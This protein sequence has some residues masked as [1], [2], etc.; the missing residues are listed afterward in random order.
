MGIIFGQRA[1]FVEVV[2]R[3][4]V[5]AA[6]RVALALMVAP[7]VAC[8]GDA[9]SLEPARVTA[10]VIGGTLSPVEDDA[11]VMLHVEGQNGVWN[12]CTATLISPRIV[13]TAKHCVSAVQ[14]GNFV[15]RGNGELVQDGTGAGVF[16]QAVDPASIAIYVGATPSGAPASRGVQVVATGSPDACHDDVAM[17]VLDQPVTVAGFIPLRW[18]VATRVGEGVTLVGYGIGDPSDGIVRRELAD[19]RIADVSA[20]DASSADSSATTPPRTFV[21]PGATVCYGDSGGPALSAETGALVGTYSRISGDCF[22]AESRNT[23]M[24]TS[25][26]GALVQEAL[27]ATGESVTVEQGAGGSCAETDCQA[28]SANAYGGASNAGSR[29]GASAPSDP[30]QRGAFKCAT[31]PGRRGPESG[32][33]LAV[34]AGLAFRRWSRCRGACADERSRTVRAD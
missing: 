11:V 2:W 18:S 33:L 32:C 10:A 25:G 8:G 28:G 9:P 29:A 15:C 31:E 3:N 1:T 7:V 23:Y 22:A 6:C 24:L 5:E 17:V 13:V 14:P 21:V 26:Y 30:A 19:V 4:R 27:A 12:D 34:L 20:A 16:G